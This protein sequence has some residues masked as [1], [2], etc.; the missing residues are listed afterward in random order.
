MST[1]HRPSDFDTLYE[2]QHG[3]FVASDPLLEATFPPELSGGP[4]PRMTTNMAH[5]PD[6]RTEDHPFL[7]HSARPSPQST[8]SAST[9]RSGTPYLPAAPLPS[10]HRRDLNSRPLRRD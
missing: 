6:R 1:I 7:P 3:R 5:R 9:Q 8:A 2:P 4:L 10:P